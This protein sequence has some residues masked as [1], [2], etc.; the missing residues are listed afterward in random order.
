MP[1]G[2]VDLTEQAKFIMQA[3]EW[4][5]PDQVLDVGIGFGS[6]GMAYRSVQLAWACL[7][8]RSSGLATPT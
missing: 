2:C 8:T 1:W 5:V 4:S 7:W 6:F 3:F